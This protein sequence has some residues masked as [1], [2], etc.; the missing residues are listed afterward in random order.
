MYVR[1][2]L[3][4]YSTFI[5]LTNIELISYVVPHIFKGYTPLFDKTKTIFAQAQAL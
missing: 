3:P 2:A 1:Q 5:G 4:I